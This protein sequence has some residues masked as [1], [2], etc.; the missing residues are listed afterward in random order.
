VNKLFYG[1]NLTV[2]RNRDYLDP[3]FNSNT[4]YNVLPKLTDAQKAEARQRRA[5]GATL[6]EIARSY[7][8]SQTTTSRSTG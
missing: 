7:N 1:D 4:S 6:G 8:V 5:Q 2:L 3:P